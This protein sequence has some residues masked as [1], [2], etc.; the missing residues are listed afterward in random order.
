[1]VSAKSGVAG[2][3]VRPGRRIPPDPIF[4]TSSSTVATTTTGVRSQLK[5]PLCGMS[6]SVHTWAAERTESL[7]LPYLSTGAFL[8]VK[9]AYSYS[10][11]T[12]KFLAC[13]LHH[14]R[15]PAA[16]Y[17]INT[18]A[19]CKISAVTISLLTM[20]ISVQC[21]D[22]RKATKSPSVAF[23]GTSV[24]LGLSSRMLIHIGTKDAAARRKMF[25]SY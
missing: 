23:E 25:F 19:V 12:R 20:A 15:M 13:G 11:G 2:S 4:T 9:D 10:T 7:V 21:G 1:M 16:R 6:P 24:G 3:R 18:D 17:E 8:C 5:P 14:F 22:N